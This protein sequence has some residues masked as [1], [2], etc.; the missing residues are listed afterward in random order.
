MNQWRQIPKDRLIQVSYRKWMRQQSM[1]DWKLKAAIEQERKQM[2]IEQAKLE[3][4]INNLHSALDRAQDMAIKWMDK[5]DA[6][7]M[8]KHGPA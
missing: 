8:E 1:L 5:T 4:T 3:N 6:L 2:K 7:L